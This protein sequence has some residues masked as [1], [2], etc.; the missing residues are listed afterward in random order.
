M[1]TIID[2]RHAG[3][4]Y[5]SHIPDVPDI[6]AVSD[7]SLT[8]PQG[9]FWVI[10]GRNGSGKSTLSRLMN[11][12]LLPKEG[13]VIIDGLHTSEDAH[14]WQIR[15]TVGV[16]F[17]NPDN[18][19][20]ATTVEED[21]AFGPENLG[22]PQPEIRKRVDDAL[23]TVAMREYLTHSP[24]MLSGGQ[25]QRVAIAGILAM[26]P[27]C[28]VLDEATSMLDPEGR[29]EVLGAIRSLHRDHGMTV[30]LITHH[31]EEA[32]GAD[33]VLVMQSGGTLIAGTPGEVFQRSVLLRAA[34]LDVPQMTAFGEALRKAGLYGGLLPVMPEEAAAMMDILF[35]QKPDSR[36]DSENVSELTGKG[37]AGLVPSID[38][39]GSAAIGD[40][41]KSSSGHFGDLAVYAASGDENPV[42]RVTDLRHVYMP[43]TLYERIALD[44]ISLSV[45]KGEILGIIGHTGSGKSTLVQHLNGL[46][47]ATSGTLEVEGKPVAAKSLKALRRKVGLIFQYP[48]HQLFEET[49]YKDIAFG[50]MQM[51]LSRDETEKRV[52]KAAALLSITPEMLEKS[53]FELSGGQKRRV[54][55]AGVLVMEPAILILDEPTAGLDPKGSREVFRLLKELN[56][57]EGT[58][59]LFISHNMEDIAAFSDRVA[60]LRDGRLAML[61]TPHAV[62]ARQQELTRMHLD[63]PAITRFFRE[64]GDRL[65]KRLPSVLTVAEAVQYVQ[66]AKNAGNNPLASGKG[67]AS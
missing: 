33:H 31:M 29:L 56:R 20:V 1:N 16:V 63:V 25:K 11:A 3:Y 57:N 30:V 34:G 9:E 26:K 51:G 47:K 32:V 2:M 5:A 62:F 12:L 37:C 18:Q 66:E 52:Q 6:I 21:V 36:D 22:V 48:E 43:G 39:D 8:I 67:D 42:I 59:I 54:A 4:R 61:D 38:P 58:T 17:Q 53:P 24:H 41:S 23:D 64:T 45:R 13:T 15:R 50:L 60:V 28:I 10:L 40:L 7:M 49:V 44:G 14:L 55:I 65:G 35:V 46:L 27:K 19:I